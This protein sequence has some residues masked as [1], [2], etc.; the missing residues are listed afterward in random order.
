MTRTKR[1]F[2]VCALVAAVTP[3]TQLIGPASYADEIGDYV[4]CARPH[5]LAVE[6]VA[7]ALFCDP[8]MI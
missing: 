4:D 3:V 5:N 6:D 8:P 1:F 7:D 2:A